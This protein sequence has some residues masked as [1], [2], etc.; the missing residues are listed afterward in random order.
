MPFKPVHINLNVME[1]SFTSIKFIKDNWVTLQ[2]GEREMKLRTKMF[3][4]TIAF[5]LTAFIGAAMLNSQILS[6]KGY[7]P[8]EPFTPDEHTLALWHLDEGQGNIIHDS[9]G[10][11][12][13]GII[14]GAAWATGRFGS[15]LDFVNSID[16]VEVQNNPDESL[17]LLCGDEF[18]VEL[19]IYARDISRIDG[20]W[21][22]WL[23]KHAVVDGVHT[24]WI[25]YACERYP[26]F[27]P[28]FYGIGSLD[29]PGEPLVPPPP[30]HQWVHIAVAYDGQSLKAY[31]NGE[32]QDSDEVG[33]NYLQGNNNPLIFGSIGPYPWQ[34]AV[35]GIIDEV[36]IS[37]VDRT[38]LVPATVSVEPDTLN[39]ASNGK[40]I[41][42]YIELP[43]DYDVTNIDVDSI[44]IAVEGQDFAVDPAASTAIGDHDGDGAADLLVKFDRAAIRNHLGEVDVDDGD[45]FYDITLAVKGNVAG[46]PFEGND[47]IMIKKK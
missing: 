47:T 28:T 24:G 9:S 27:H 26:M 36:R 40:W 44:T 1:V 12:N 3:R 7:Y 15:G 25:L 16:Y 4:I 34:A 2:N 6:A 21:N 30:T 19:W 18:T 14:Y 33:H 37:S 31:Y 39:L 10:H 46:T 5:M 17:N 11:G 41:S 29:A 35:D 20:Y 22:D 38:K 43:E 23:R 13:D 42:T 8:N 45:K 32:L